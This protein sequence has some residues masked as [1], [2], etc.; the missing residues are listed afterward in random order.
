MQTTLLQSLGLLV[1]HPL[2]YRCMRSAAGLTLATLKGPVRF[3]N[4]DRALAL[5]V[6]RTSPPADFL[7]V[8]IS[9]GMGGM[10]DGG[11]AASLAI[12]EFVAEAGETLR[13]GSEPLTDA[14]HRANE[15]VFATYGGLGGA[16]LTA[17][18]FVKD[19]PA[20][21]IHNGDSRLYAR[22]P[23][24]ALALLTRD[25]TPN[26]LIAGDDNE[27]AMSSELIQFVGIGA[28]FAPTVTAI[29]RVDGATWLLTSDGA[30]D[31]R[32]RQLQ[33]ILDACV[34][35]EDTT[36]LLIDAADAAGAHD[37]ATVA[38]VRPDAFW[39]G[40]GIEKGAGITAWTPAAELF[41]A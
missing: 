31:M 18:V 11:G 21:L 10:I 1:R 34:D 16:T 25:D 4:Q 38:A 29:D 27:S 19:G 7:I 15:A 3:E 9:D 13:G 33:A 2:P 26:G 5:H 41:L 14:A 17:A 28:R 40:E 8:A 23:G 12:S 6:R 39:G 35:A 30:H 36:R 20:F 32:R 24:G 37:N 22:P